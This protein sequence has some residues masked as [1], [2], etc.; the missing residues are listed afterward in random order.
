[1]GAV[2]LLFVVQR[3]PY[4]SENARLAL[5]HAIA[6]QTAEIYMDDGDSVVPIIVF[7]GDGVLNMVKDQ[8]AMKVY[9]VTSTESHIKSCLLIDLPVWVCKEDMT[10]LGLKEENVITDAEDMGAELKTKFVSFADIQ[11][12]MESVKHLL[13]F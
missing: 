9:G 5:T 8:Q 13:F 7:V 12:E 4:K 1:M 3:P 10:R 2:N 6:S 11:K